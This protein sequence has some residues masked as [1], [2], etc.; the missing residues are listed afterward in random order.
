MI[1]SGELHYEASRS[2][3]PGGQHVNKTSTR[4][5]LRWNV[6]ESRVLPER[7]RQLLLS[8]LAGRLN[9]SGELQLNADGSRSRA[10]NRDEVRERLASLVGVALCVPNERRPTQPTRSSTER[11]LHSKR[12]RSERKRERGNV[13]PEDE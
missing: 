6:R 13:R 3:G 10:R 5:T 8:Q 11:R 9:Q 2:G 12:Q 1:P 4:V 7:T